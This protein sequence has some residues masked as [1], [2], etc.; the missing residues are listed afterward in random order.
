[1]PH[2]ISD[3]CNT[4]VSGFK[5][6]Y[7]LPPTPLGWSLLRLCGLVPEHGSLPL[8]WPGTYKAE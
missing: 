6:L 8:L 1:M 3:S 4:K 7:S 2:A 5:K